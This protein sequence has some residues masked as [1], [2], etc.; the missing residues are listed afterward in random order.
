MKGNLSD[1]IIF[2]GFADNKIP[3]FKEITSKEW[4][5]FGEDNLFPLHILYLFNKSSNHNAIINGKVNYIC[6]KG[7]KI[8]NTKLTKVNRNGE[9]IN[10]VMK[11]A[12]IDVELFG[13][14][15]LEII[16]NQSGGMEVFH[17]PFQSLR[18][19]KDK[20]GFWH[21]KDWKS[22]KRDHEYIPAF[23]PENRIGKQIFA[24]D[25]YRPGCD[26]YPLPGYFG[27]LNDIET[28]VE[29]SKYNLSVIK[30]GMFSSKMIVFNTGDPGEEAKKKLEK[31]FR[32]KFAGSDNAGR[33]MM[34]FNTEP[35]KA[36]I[37]NDLSTTDLD[38]L[39][40]QLNKTTQSEIFSGHQVTSPML[41]GVKTEGELGGRTE[42]DTAYEIFKNT[43]V[44]DKQQA[45]EESF[46]VFF[47]YFG[48]NE[49][50]KITPVNPLN[51]KLSDDKMAEIMPKEWI[52]E[53]MGI[54]ITKYPSLQSPQT[55]NPSSL[56]VNENVKNLTGK[57]HQQLTRIIRQFT[58]GKITKAVAVTMLKTSL[59][60]A[61][62]EI[63]TMLCTDEQFSAMEEDMVADM[64][65]DIGEQRDC[66]HVVKS[67]PMEFLTQEAEFA[68][69]KETDSS[70]LDLIKKDKRITS[71]VIGETLKMEP[72]YVEARIKKLEEKGVLTRKIN[73][74][75]IDTIIERAVVP[76]MID[77]REPAE[78]V[79][80][81]IRYSYEPRPGLDPIIETT[82]PF[83]RKLIKLN[84]VYSRAEIESVSQ[85]VGYSVWDRRGGFWGNKPECRH[86]W[87]RN[88][89]I[90]KK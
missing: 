1:N 2:I 12:S 66:F 78:T 37:I 9:S 80:I 58:Q 42:M 5:T 86:I 27:A 77:T 22:Y 67:K 65:D 21:K 10:K 84:K 30:Q 4:I 56:P 69:I 16:W 44:N 11:K 13:G 38:K 8:E 35:S 33:F 82:R 57:Q 81:F 71:K 26:A 61:D 34:V 72:S 49:E 90:K 3:E 32:D 31:G 55:T 64:F 74:I 54:D 83:C 50:L 68:D 7:F 63:E 48:V 43:Y 75:G 20:K 89:V 70:I 60:L 23:N 29:I 76:E 25:E 88:I 53:Q 15:R 17:I 18:I 6:G 14:Y 24:Y 45:L 79:D 36:P 47:P 28:D 46:K 39:F 59:G 73:T 52:M 51:F 19:A 85:R 87:K 40:D 62:E 41:F